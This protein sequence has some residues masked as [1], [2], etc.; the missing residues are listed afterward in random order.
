MPRVS[1]LSPF[2]AVCDQWS[3]GCCHPCLYAQVFSSKVI[4]DLVKLTGSINSDTLVEDTV[5]REMRK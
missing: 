1:F 3:V 5:L 4:L 2:Y